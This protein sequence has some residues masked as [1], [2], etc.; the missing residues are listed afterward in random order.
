MRTTRITVPSTPS[1][2]KTD[3]CVGLMTRAPGGAEDLLSF[4]LAPGDALVPG[5]LDDLGLAALDL[6]GIGVGVTD[7]ERLFGKKVPL[8]S[9]PFLSWSHF[10]MW[11]WRRSGRNFLPQWMHTCRLSGGAGPARLSRHSAAP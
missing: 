9:S 3:D 4:P 1:Q 11:I 2:G 6:F 10:S 5:D 7:S 8:R